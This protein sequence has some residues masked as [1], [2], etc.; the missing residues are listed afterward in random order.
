MSR[1]WC[2]TPYS[3]AK[4]YL[5]LYDPNRTCA[6]TLTM[7]GRECTLPCAHAACRLVTHKSCRLDVLHSKMYAALRAAL[8]ARHAEPLLRLLPRADAASGGSAAA[9]AGALRLRAL[10][11]QDELDTS[12]QA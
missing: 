8:G 11:A 4:V 1:L 9:I 2:L 10:A 12:L 5:Y 3:A 7:H 6:R